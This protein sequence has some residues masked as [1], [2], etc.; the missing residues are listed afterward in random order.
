MQLDLV[1][2]RR[3]K[4]LISNRLRRMCEGESGLSIATVREKERR[5]T[6]PEVNNTDDYGFSGKAAPPTMPGRGLCIP[7]RQESIFAGGVCDHSTL[8]SSNARLTAPRRTTRVNASLLVY[9]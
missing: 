3:R 1:L 7:G 6:R 9:C 2:Q 4:Q 5:P 8:G